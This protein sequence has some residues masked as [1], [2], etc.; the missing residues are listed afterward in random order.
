MIDY[1]IYRQPT[2]YEG[3]FKYVAP[4]GYRWFVDN[5]DY[6]VI[7]YGEYILQNPYELKQ[8]AVN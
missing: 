3:L 8:V 4:E 2:Q 5:T 6:G 1:G 7:I